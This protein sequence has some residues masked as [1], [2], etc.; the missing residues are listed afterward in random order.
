MSAKHQRSR[1]LSSRLP[2]LLLW[3]ASGIIV[4]MLCLRFGIRAVGVRGD[5]PLPRLI[6][7][8]TAPLVAPFYTF[9]PVS[10]RCRY[11]AV[12]VASLVA[13]GVA[14]AVTLGIYVLRLLISDW[15]A[16]K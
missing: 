12:E 4:T 11:H 2:L 10:T 14:I 15:I 8:L 7:S 5:I 3:I 16:Q 6:Y 9:F 13:A 1:R